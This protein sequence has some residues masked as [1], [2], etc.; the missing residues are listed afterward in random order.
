VHENLLVQRRSGG[1]SRVVFSLAA[2]LHHDERSRSRV[3][4]RR[5]RQ[6]V[7]ERRLDQKRMTSLA[8]APSLAVT[9]DVGVLAEENAQRLVSIFM[10]AGMS[11][12]LN[13]KDVVE[14][15]LRSKGKDPSAFQKFYVAGLSS[16][17]HWSSDMLQIEVADIEA[18]YPETRK[19]HQFVFVSILSEAVY[20]NS[21]ANLVIP[22]ISETYHAFLKRIVNTSDVQRGTAFLEMPLCHRRVV[23]LEAFRNAYHDMARRCANAQ[24]LVTVS[25]ALAHRASTLASM[26]Q[27]GSTDRKHRA[28]NGSASTTT[29]EDVKP[30]K[31]R[32]QRAML[33]ASETPLPP[34]PPPK[35]PPAASAIGAVDGA[36][37]EKAPSELA[38]EKDAKNVVL[39]DSPAF[40]EEERSVTTAAAI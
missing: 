33:E 1:V 40:F 4:V 28:T 10:E 25:S 15:E 37:S 31:S 21:M 20:S 34:L 9:G 6:A 18:Q 38:P 17:G 39:L 3:L 24:E 2:A 12:I 30:T 32:L 36:P 22:S 29:S 11:C 8:L 13:L 5:V 23:F 35:T 16:I 27:E 14:K 26:S 7:E 19:L